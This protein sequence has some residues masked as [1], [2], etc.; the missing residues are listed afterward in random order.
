MSAK[1]SDHQVVIDGSRVQFSCSAAHAATC[2]LGCVLECE[3]YH[4]PECDRTVKDAGSC[5]ALVYFDAVDPFDTYIGG[6]DRQDWRSGPIDI[7]WDT[8]HDSWLW[9]FPGEDRQ[10]PG[11]ARYRDAV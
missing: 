8:Y 4:S 9:R 11:H 3:D 1:G 6:T 7:E 10:L 2:R 5:G